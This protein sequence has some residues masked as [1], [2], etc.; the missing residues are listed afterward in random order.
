VATAVAVDAGGAE[1]MQ[2]GITDLPAAVVVMEVEVGQ[3]AVVVVEAEAVTVAL[4]TVVV[5]VVDTVA[6]VAE[7]GGEFDNQRSPVKP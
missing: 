7:D 4:S 5:A 1:A 6:A 2:A 3:G